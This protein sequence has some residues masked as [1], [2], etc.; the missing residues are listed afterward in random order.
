MLKKCI[1]PL[2]LL[3]TVYTLPAQKETAKAIADTLDEKVYNMYDIQV[4]PKFPGGEQ[5]MLKFIAENFRCLDAGI[6]S[7]GALKFVVRKDGSITDIEV[8]KEIGGG[9]AAEAV[10]VIGLMPKWTP[11]Q[12]RG[13]AVNVNYILPMRICFK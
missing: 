11:G 10:R 5:A 9:F 7:T 2:F 12:A 1:L 6:S 4:S 8:V 3:F 13:H